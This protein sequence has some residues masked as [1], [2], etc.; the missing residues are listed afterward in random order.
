MHLYT[1]E[2]TM[3]TFITRLALCTALALIAIHPTAARAQSQQEMNQD[4][5]RAYETADGT[6]NK[7]YKELL[8]Q[9]DKE[10]QEKLKASQRA[11]VLFRDAQAEFEADL[12]ARGGSMAPLI[13]NEA[14]KTLTETRTK[15]LGQVKTDGSAE[16]E[17][18]PRKAG[19]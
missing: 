15:E 10:S 16:N 19:S 4:A 9:L 13:Y 6:L 2:Q 12:E 18:E 14:R 3:K 8:A 7:V 17:E 1:P 5:A 11:W